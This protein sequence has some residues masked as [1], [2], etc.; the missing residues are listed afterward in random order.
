MK[1][2]ALTS[3]DKQE[4]VRASCDVHESAPGFAP[5]PLV[6]ALNAQG[7]VALLGARATVSQ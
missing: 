5:D 4:W 6:P 1:R 2:G 7:Q 3:F